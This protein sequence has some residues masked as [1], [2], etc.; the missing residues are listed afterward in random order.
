MTEIT[1]HGLKF[2]VEA[3]GFCHAEADQDAGIE[4]IS[5]HLDEMDK[6]DVAAAHADGIA[7]I[8]GDLFGDRPAIFGMLECVGHAEATLGWHNP[9]AAGFMV[10]AIR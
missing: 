8:D 6:S 10:S 2:I 1:I 7:W 9:S 4:A 5:A 3:S